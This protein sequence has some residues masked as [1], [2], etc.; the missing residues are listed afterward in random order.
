[1]KLRA[2][3]LLAVGAVVASLAFAP[4]GAVV[5]TV[6][7]AK[8]GNEWGPAKAVI[9][10]GGKVTWKNTDFQEHNVRAYGG[11]WTKDTYLFERG[12]T[13]SKR[14]RKPGTYTYLCSIHGFKDSSGCNG[15]CGKVV[16]KKPS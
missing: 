8:A 15:M 6:V 1:M 14:F 12:D 2:A 10:K 11:G 4:A 5:N 13:T 7:K 3:R 16:V 9:V